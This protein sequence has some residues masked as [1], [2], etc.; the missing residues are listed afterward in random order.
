MLLLNEPESIL[1]TAM[2][3]LGNALLTFGMLMALAMLALWGF[4]EDRA[5]YISTAHQEQQQPPL[6]AA[7]IGSALRVRLH[8]PG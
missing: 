1:N 4:A 3:K 5:P 2:R 8:P 7:P 6:Q